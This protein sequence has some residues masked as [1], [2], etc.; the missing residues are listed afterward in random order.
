MVLHKEKKKNQTC[1]LPSRRTRAK[2]LPAA[3]SA[4]KKEDENL[5]KKS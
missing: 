1:P 3:A 2:Q 5:K 4:A